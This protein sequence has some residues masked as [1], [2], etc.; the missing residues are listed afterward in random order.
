MARGF[1]LMRTMQTLSPPSWLVVLVA[2]VSTTACIPRNPPST[3]PRQS[4]A[5]HP[6][7][8]TQLIEPAISSWTFQNDSQ[9]HRYQ[10]VNVTTVK[11]Q[12]EATQ[13]EDTVTTSM[14]FTLAL[15]RSLV[16]YNISGEITHTSI[17]GGHQIGQD[18][19]HQM[20]SLPFRGDYH[21]NRL[22]IYIEGTRSNT[23]PCTDTTTAQLTRLYNQV[24]R[25][26]PVIQRGMIWHD[27]LTIQSC[28]GPIPIEIRA[29]RH[30]QV[31]GET[32]IADQRVV[33][34]DRSDSVQT[35]GQ[36]SQGEHQ[37]SIE[38]QGTGETKLFLN[39]S[40]ARV[41][42]SDSKQVTNVLTRTSGR[43]LRFTQQSR[44]S[45]RLIP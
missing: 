36:G 14:T 25:I 20:P 38:A 8:P 15:D 31:V 40:T 23:V 22:Q 27:S 10:L 18:I 26:P 44:E 1:A 45:V 41:A 30:Y 17:K 37:I 2:A 6:I 32:A 43:L 24:D 9:S 5:N 4:P 29:I 35:S 28:H 34:I 21:D 33:L 7:Q 19:P 13:L 12:A 39:A 42:A 11:L 16:V 3:S